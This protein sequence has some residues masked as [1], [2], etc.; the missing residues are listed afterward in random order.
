MMVTKQK[1]SGFISLIG[2]PSSGKST[3]I[4]SICG[5]KVTIAS[6]HPQTTRYLIRGIYNDD[7]SQIVFIDSPGYH[8]FNS[9]LNRGLSNLAV[10]N[11]DEGDFILYV[12]D[13]ARNFGEEENGIIEKVI[14]F[15]HKLIIVF[16]KIDVDK[17]TDIRE[18]VL[19]RVTPILSFE[20]SALRNKG[21]KDM[22]SEIKKVMSLGDIFYPDDYVT[23]QS[24]PFRVS[25]IVREKIFLFSKEEVPHSCYVEV[26][27]FTLDE[28][29]LT[30]N[31]VIYVEKESQKGILIGA[32][33]SMIK[34]IGGEARKMLQDI[35][36]RDVNLFLNV[37]LNLNWR[38]KDQFIKKMFDLE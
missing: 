6:K 12:I 23:D 17:K 10:R 14:K 11:L 20:V 31:A 15:S 1:K 16:N 33:G 38:K 32:K 5:Y 26:E 21:V 13:A 35:F 36:E 24:V 34:K 8:N 18:E 28:K 30:A 27:K 22:I 29:L 2:R 4:N 7:E 9:N 25:E 37:K 19:S 3:L